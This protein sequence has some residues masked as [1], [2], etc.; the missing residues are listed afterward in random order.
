MST[1]DATGGMVA[2]AGSL[3]SRVANHSHKRIE[4]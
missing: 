3:D 4:A 2:D 1:P